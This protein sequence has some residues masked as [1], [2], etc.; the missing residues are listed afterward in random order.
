MNKLDAN[1]FVHILVNF[2]RSAM[3]ACDTR[4]QKTRD[5]ALF[6]I[7]V[8]DKW[9]K[10]TIL[11]AGAVPLLLDLLDSET[12]ETVGVVL[13]MLSS[14]LI[15]KVALEP[16]QRFSIQVHHAQEQAALSLLLLCTNIFV[17][18]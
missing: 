3:D 4:V 16:L 2:L 12:Y 5:L 6:N 8:N 1:G 11:D 17:H 18:S 15:L 13:L 14:F 10:A 9:N 7:M